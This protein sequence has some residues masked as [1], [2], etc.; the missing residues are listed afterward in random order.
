MS[1]VL[2]CIVSLV[3]SIMELLV[4]LGLC[5]YL[6]VCIG[7]CIYLVDVVVDV[8][9]VGGMKDVNICKLCVFVLMYVIVNVDENWCEIV[10]VFCEFVFFI[11]VMYL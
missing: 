9:K 4:V 10:D 1:V 8:F 5:E 3:L 6:V 7:F 2:L 11:V